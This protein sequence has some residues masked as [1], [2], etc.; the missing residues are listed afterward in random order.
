MQCCDLL[1]PFPRCELRFLHRNIQKRRRKSRAVFFF[2]RAGRQ[3]DKMAACWCRQIDSRTWC[4]EGAHT[5]TM[6]ACFSFS[7]RECE[8]A[9][10]PVI[11]RHCCGGKIVCVVPGRRCPHIGTASRMKVSYLRSPTVHVRS[12]KQQQRANDLKPERQACKRLPAA[13]LYRTSIVQA[14]SCSPCACE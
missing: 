10:L 13:C 2:H 12:E 8:V 1:P 5:P 9:R 7:G 6:K 3:M 11:W 4:V 14:L